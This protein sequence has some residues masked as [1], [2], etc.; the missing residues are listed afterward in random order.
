MKAKPSNLFDS[1]SGKMGNAVARRVGDTQVIARYYHT[2]PIVSLEARNQKAAFGELSQI[3]KAKSSAQRAIYEAL[4]AY[5]PMQDRYSVTYYPTAYQLFLYLNLTVYAFSGNEITSP[6]A[7]FPQP[8]PYVR[9]NEFYIQ[10][11]SWVISLHAGTENTN[12]VSFY[13][14]LPRASTNPVYI[15]DSKLI[16]QQWGTSPLVHD[17]YEDYEYRFGVISNYYENL[18]L[19]VRY[20][21][22]YT[23]LSSSESALPA[24][25][26]N[27]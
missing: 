27:E 23:G 15:G 7:P 24:V 26:L 13:A 11:R 14:T 2:R 16:W 22:S 10:S 21:S 17:L 18:Y 1:L 4:I 20:T 5:Y 3:W 12:I 19:F 9:V 6:Q 25:I 8:E